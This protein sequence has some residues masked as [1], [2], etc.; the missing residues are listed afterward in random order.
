MKT[1]DSKTPP[2]QPSPGADDALVATA[3]HEAGHA[4]M[5]VSLG[6]HIHKV[7]IAP[8]K[9][10]FGGTRLGHCEIKKGRAKGVNDRLEDDVLILLAG[11]VAEARFTGQYCHRG[12]GRDLDDV[13]NLLC[14]R[15]ASPRQH[16]T[17]R[18][19]MIAKTEH[20]LS[21]DAHVAAIRTIAGELLD[22]TTISGRAVRHHFQQAQQRHP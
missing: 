1:P 11:M 19:R 14:T 18:R 8:G 16:E 17:L 10:A 13:A 4:V 9:M 7:T 5:A 21:D 20:I 2:T 22:K 3:H 6:R 12:A 15:A